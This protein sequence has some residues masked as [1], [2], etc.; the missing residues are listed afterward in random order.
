MKTF[1]LKTALL[2]CGFSWSLPR[3]LKIQPGEDVT[4]QCSKVSKYDSITF[5]FRLINRTKV[6][7]ISVMFPGDD[8]AK[9]CEGFESGSFEMSSNISTVFLKIK[10]VDFSESGLYFCGF[11]IN[12]RLN[13]SV[14][15]LHVKAT[16]SHHEFDDDIDGECQKKSFESTNLLSL[17][18]GGLTVFLI[19]VIVG[20]VVQIKK[21]QKADDKQD[22]QENGS[23]GSDDVDYATVTFKQTGRRRQ[24]ESNVVYAAT[25]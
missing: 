20:L 16:K 2:L 24:P 13:F 25:R 22:P 18:L 9:Y 3:T 17:I 6:N 5:W 4:L 14:I 1:P 10:E 7:C 15:H 8:K 19:A 21:L 11:Y 23:P 12:A